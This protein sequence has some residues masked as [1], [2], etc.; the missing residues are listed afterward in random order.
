M[1]ARAFSKYYENMVIMKKIETQ[2]CSQCKKYHTLLFKNLQTD[3]QSRLNF[4]KD[5][6]SFCNVLF[7]TSVKHIFKDR[8]SYIL[9]IM[10]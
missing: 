9:D 6:I 2:E 4:S 8:K 5:G 10:L 7:S 1:S 3:R